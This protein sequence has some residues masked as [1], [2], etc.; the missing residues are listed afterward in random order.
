MCIYM[1]VLHDLHTCGLSLHACVCIFACVYAFMGL[2]ACIPSLHVCVYMFTYVH[3]LIYM[4]VCIYL[5][6]CMLSLH[7]YM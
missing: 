4:C 6:I 5:H 3:T 2:H 7:V 1:H